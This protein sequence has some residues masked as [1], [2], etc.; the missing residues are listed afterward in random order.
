MEELSV[1]Q[2]ASVME[3]MDIDKDER[4]FMLIDDGCNMSCIKRRRHIW[5]NRDN[6]RAP[7]AIVAAVGDGSSSGGSGR[8]GSSGDG[9][10]GGGRV[11]WEYG[12][13][14]GWW[15]SMSDEDSCTLEQHWQK[16][17]SLYVRSIAGDGR[18]MYEFSLRELTQY[19][20]YFDGENWVVVKTRPLRR[21]VV[22]N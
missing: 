6:G 3:V 21:I 19:R 16:G 20:K 13:K 14:G 5:M 12:A 8:A 4:I 11:V 22:L 10:C 9:G 17:M 1:S 15:N 2:K 7:A 18:S